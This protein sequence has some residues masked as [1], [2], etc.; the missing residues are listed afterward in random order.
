[1]H[2]ETDLVQMGYALWQ[3]SIVNK[4][5]IYHL[6]AEPRIRFAMHLQHYT[7]CLYT[8][9]KVFC[10]HMNLCRSLISNRLFLHMKAY[11]DVANCKY[12]FTKSEQRIAAGRGLQGPK[13]LGPARFQF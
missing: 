8:N 6:L 7:S 11:K 5:Q 9:V 13:F 3:I 12:I 10:I 2:G 1:M 4:Y